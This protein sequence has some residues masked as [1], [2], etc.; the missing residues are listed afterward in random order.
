MSEATKK[1]AGGFAR[2]AAGAAAP[3]FAKPTSPKGLAWLVHFVLVL[4]LVVGSY[5][6]QKYFNLTEIIGKGIPQFKEFWLPILVLLAYAL[7]W[8]AAWLWAQLAPEQS[9]ISFPDLDEAWDRICESLERAGIGL[10][11]TPVFLVLGDLPSGLDPV[12]RALPRAPAVIGGTSSDA[13]IRAYASSDA[14]YITLTGASLL[15]VQEAGGIV[16]LSTAGNAQDSGLAMNSLGIGQSVGIGFGGESIGAS[17]TGSIGA[18][19]AGGGPLREIQ[20]VIQGAKAEGRPLNDL[21]K[22][23]IR[24]LSSGPAQAIKPIPKANP[25]APISVLNNADLVAESEARLAYIAERIAKSRWPLCPINGL[26][27]A[28]PLAAIERDDAAQQWGLVARHDLSVLTDVLKMQ[29]PTFALLGGVELLPGGA[30]F[31][32]TFATD[33]ANQRLGK[34]FPL[35]PDASPEQTRAAIEANA[36]WVLGGLLPY[37]ALK[38]TKVSGAAS[39][40][41]DNAACIRF[42]DAARR[43][44]PHLGR[45]LSRALISE[46]MPPCYGGCYLTVASVHDAGEAKFAK[47]F[48]KKLESQQA[49]VAWTEAAYESDAS[50]RKW[51]VGGT[52]ALIAIA[53]AVIGLG[54]YVFT[55]PR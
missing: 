53:L 13:P 5:F 44:A 48:F 8:S 23:R 25:G 15:G 18:S 54:V 34:G 20:R 9:S 31:F 2:W 30:R 28:V 4:V 37:W 39:D 7:V 33:K 11:D 47:D 12:F 45:L 10:G 36:N 3:M 1:S 51:A 50:Y 21:E 52:V 41:D 42:Y 14:I 38:M 6:I 40:T 26:V 16:E 43:R 32:D 22:E 17:L 24:Q 49:F 35:N 55:R 46:E 27:L 29:F 19:I